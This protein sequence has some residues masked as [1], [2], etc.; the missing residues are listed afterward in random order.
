MR[1]ESNLDL[2]TK[3]LHDPLVV[4]WQMLCEMAGH[5]CGMKV[6]STMDDSEKSRLDVVIY[7]LT[8]NTLFDVR[9]VVG[10]DSGYCRVRGRN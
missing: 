4:V 3:Y 5:R 8:E 10:G 7:R 9:T 1:C 6:T 2:Q